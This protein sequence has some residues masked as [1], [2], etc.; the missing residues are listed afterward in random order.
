MNG[1]SSHGRLG[2]WKK[3]NDTSNHIFIYFL[4]YKLLKVPRTLVKIKSPKAYRQMLK[5]KNNVA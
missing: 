5:L 1:Q 4:N 3:Q 2:W